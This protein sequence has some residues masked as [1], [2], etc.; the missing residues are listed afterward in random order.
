MYCPPLS[1]PVT[2][3]I[4][5][6]GGNRLPAAL[7]IPTPSLF[8]GCAPQGGK[9]FLAPNRRRE[10]SPVL[11]SRQNLQPRLPDI[12]ILIISRL[13][14]ITP[15]AREWGKLFSSPPRLW[16]GEPARHSPTKTLP[17]RKTFRLSVLSLSKALPRALFSPSFSN[18]PTL[19]PLVDYPHLSVAHPVGCSFALLSSSR[20]SR[21]RQASREMITRRGGGGVG[22]CCPRR[23]GELL[24]PSSSSSDVHERPDS[25][26]RTFARQRPN[27]W[28]KR[29]RGGG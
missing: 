10:D 1:I 2:H 29:R 15:Q 11:A 27:K 3:I 25:G 7:S 4:G 26:R 17:K 8:S 12:I 22:G 24:A 5:G 18:P 28:G 19:L 16:V 20:C 9:S 6:G 21:A 23:K 14:P 13:P